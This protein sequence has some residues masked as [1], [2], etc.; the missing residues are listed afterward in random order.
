[1]AYEINMD[2]DGILHMAFIGDMDRQS[3]EAF[4]AEFEP[5]LE[6]A[7]EAKPLRIFVN[8]RR[9]GK[10]TSGARKIF[11]EMYKSPK[12]GAV[13]LVGAPRYSRV[14]VGFVAKATG[15]DIIHLFDSDEEALAWLRGQNLSSS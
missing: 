6:S 12:I 13:A 8:G 10:Y 5:F 3:L 1:M 7:T 15:R 14:L 4:G 9:S 11:V 2:D